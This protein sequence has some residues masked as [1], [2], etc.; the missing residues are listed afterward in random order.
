MFS[1]PA[2]TRCGLHFQSARNNDGA[3]KAALLLR[4]YNTPYRKRLIKIHLSDYEGSRFFFTPQPLYFRLFY[5]GHRK[6]YPAAEAVAAGP[7]EC[8]RGAIISSTPCI[9][10]LNSTIR[11]VFSRTRVLF[12]LHLVPIS[13][14][15]DIK[16][17][18]TGSTFPSALE[19]LRLR[20]FRARTVSDT[21]FVMSLATIRQWHKRYW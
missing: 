14:S 17:K 6:M 8:W 12:H 11:F 20:H 2:G 19:W 13:R 7:C 10:A 18:D 3:I 21:N 16:T 15:T 4:G 1:L 5:A 9:R